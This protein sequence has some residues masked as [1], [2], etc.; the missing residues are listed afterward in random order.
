MFDF[1]TKP[2]GWLLMLL[3]E[4]TINYGFAVI[5]FALVLKIILLPFQY[6]SK[7]S[8]MQTS[9]LQPKLKELE[10]RHGANKQKYNEEVAKLYREEKINPMS[11]CL[12][13]LLP[14]PILLALFAAIRD[15]LT[16]MMGVPKALLEQGGAIANKLSELG[17]STTMNNNYIQIA[18]TQFISEHFDKFAG[19]SDKLRMI[20]Y[21]F[22]GMN[23]GDTPQFNFLW[24]TNWND[25]SVWLPGL[26]L[27]TLPIISGVLA[28]LSSKI[29]M[30]IN[31]AGDQQQQNTTKTMLLLM[32]LI[33]VYFAFIMPGSIGIYIIASTLFA[34]IQDIILTK[35]FKRI[36]DAEDAVKLERQKEKEA[37]LEAKHLET[38]RKKAENMTE[39]NPNTSKKKQHKSERQEQLEKAADWEKKHSD[40]VEE[41]DP[42]RVGTRRFA[43]GRAYD[44][45]RFGDGVALDDAATDAPDE[46]M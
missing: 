9:R 28:F 15:P 8:M 41:T 17:F 36:L 44:P 5:L 22:L 1:I 2:F 31:T 37:E 32:P 4:V 10:K 35:R 19:L 25:V 39:R 26:L 6:K 29:S 16:I 12:W 42:S 23:L 7:R 24:T 38:E 40:T 34:M 21:N 33:N 11:G 43:R 30:Q 27:F 3:Y 45:E 14:F 20:D 13:S 46:N 18:Q